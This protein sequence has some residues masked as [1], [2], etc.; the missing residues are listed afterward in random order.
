VYLQLLD[1]SDLEHL[2]LFADEVNRQL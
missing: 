1:L 2:R